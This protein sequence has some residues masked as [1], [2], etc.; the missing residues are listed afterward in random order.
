MPKI[1]DKEEVRGR[2]LDATMQVYSD[3]GFHAATI[4]GIAKASGM[5]KGTLYLYFDSKE[6]LTVALADRIFGGMGGAF[7]GKSSFD[8]VDAF[9]AHLKVT[10]TTTEERAK[11]VRVFFEVF[12]PSFASADFVKSV[13][14]FFDELGDYYAAEL[15][16]LQSIGEV[17]ADL[18]CSIA[19]RSLAAMVDGV[20][21]HRGLFAISKSRHGKMINAALDL[22]IDGM[23]PH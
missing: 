2:I 5:G 11:F 15:E 16:R 3:V 22:L 10:M 1:V 4:S 8:T 12:G 18:D 6:A 21:L 13:A 7:M 20:I 17:R 14:S 23:R 9:K 19:G